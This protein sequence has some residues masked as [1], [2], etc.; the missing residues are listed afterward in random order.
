M[1]PDPRL[2]AERIS[3]VTGLA[4]GCG[5]TAFAEA[6]CLALESGGHGYARIAVGVDTSGEKP[7]RLPRGTVFCTSGAFLAEAGCMPEV[8]GELPSPSALGRLAIARATRPGEARLA[9]PERNEDLSYIVETIRA[10]GWASSVV[11]DG[12]LNR[13]TQAAGL[14]GVR[15]FHAAR[16]GRADFRSV[17]RKLRHVRRLARLPA[18]RRA[19]HADTERDSGDSSTAFLAGPVTPSVLDGLPSSV[20]RVVAED[21]TKLFL[22]E[23]EF[24]RYSA[25]IT[26][27]LGKSI[28]FGGFS[29][30]LR[31]IDAVEFA[32]ELGDAAGD[33]VCW[34]AYR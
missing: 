2:F 10:E 30:A 33:V 21:F 5:K 20:S 26:F 19:P 14:E 28:D 16:A 3:I 7:T 11:V 1:L 23:A 34:D 13:I 24:S 25:G 6:I 15:L 18:G 8:L 12:S 32:A 4:K 29:I 17:A 27:E 22:D 31:D 9:G